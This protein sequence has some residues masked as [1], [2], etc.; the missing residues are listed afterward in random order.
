MSAEKNMSKGAPV[1]NLGEDIAGRPEDQLEVVASVLLE[2]GGD[3]LEMRTANRR[4]PLF[5]APHKT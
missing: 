3:I 4:P 1:L 5:P 2:A